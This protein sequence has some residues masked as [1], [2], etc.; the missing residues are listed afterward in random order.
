MHASAVYL[1]L[2]VS[3][4]DTLI[5]QSRCDGLHR[6]HNPAQAQLVR[7]AGPGLLPARVECGTPLTQGPGAMD[8]WRRARTF[9]MNRKRRGGDGQVQAINSAIAVYWHAA[10]AQTKT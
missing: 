10:A 4:A 6:G 9:R 2:V 1:Q 3:G 7:T 8:E 5:P